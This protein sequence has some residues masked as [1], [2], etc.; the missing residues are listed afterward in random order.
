MQ[1]KLLQ[2]PS[3]YHH[4]SQVLPGEEVP[5]GAYRCI[6][7]MSPLSQGSDSGVGCPWHSTA[8]RPPFPNADPSITG[9]RQG[10]LLLLG[11]TPDGRDAA[12][13]RG[14]IL[15]LQASLSS[16]LGQLTAAA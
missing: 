4:S 14:H 12:A 7:H 11:E 2:F 8:G 13:H 6:R 15:Q 5:L 10:A 9:H 3:H 1:A 16:G